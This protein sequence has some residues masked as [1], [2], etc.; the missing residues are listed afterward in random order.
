MIQI[1]KITEGMNAQQ[2]ADIIYDNFME[3][4]KGYSSVNLDDLKAELDKDI[5]SLKNELYQF[6]KTMVEECFG[7]KLFYDKMMSYIDIYFTSDDI[8]KKLYE[9]INNLIDIYLTTGEMLE[10]IESILVRETDE[11]FRN[12]DDYPELADVFKTYIRNIITQEYRGKANGLASL[13]ANG[14]VPSSQLPS[15]VDDVLEGYYVDPITFYKPDSVTKYTPETGKIYVDLDS[16][17]ATCYRWSGSTFVL[18]SNP[19]VIGT[20][21]GTAYDGASGQKNAND[22]ASLKTSVTTVTN[23]LTTEQT[24]RA[25]ADTNLQNQINSLSSRNTF[26]TDEKN[27]LAGIAAGADNVTFTAT[28]TSGTKIGTITINGTATDIYIPIWNGTLSDYNALTKNSN[29]IYNIIE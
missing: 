29:Y 2:V 26:T 19:L 14:L 17:P 22:I 6:A 5:A 13:D 4:I 28:Y 24:A 11:I 9:V 23:N 7:D 8:T 20:T 18:I 21:A 10:Y 1:K 15:Y 3:V 25:N 16:N 12:I 27:K